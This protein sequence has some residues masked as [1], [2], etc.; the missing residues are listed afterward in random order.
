M[1]G[2][3]QRQTPGLQFGQHDFGN[4]IGNIAAVGRSIRAKHLLCKRN[5]IKGCLFRR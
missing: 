1:E 2:M 5:D 4:Q 3:A